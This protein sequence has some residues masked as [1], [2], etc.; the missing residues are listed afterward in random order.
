MKKLILCVCLLT[1]LSGCKKTENGPATSLDGGVLLLIENQEGASLLDPSIE[2]HLDISKI[3]HYY[4]IDGKK[5][6]QNRTNYEAPKMMRIRYHEAYEIYDLYVALDVV[7][8]EGSISTSIIE[9]DGLP[10]DTISIEV[11]NPGNKYE[12]MSYSRLWING[13]EQDKPHHHHVLIK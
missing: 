8:K 1:L 5:V 13:E 2:G 12:A 10:A 11:Y 3:N 6:L 4:L 7:K 9:Y